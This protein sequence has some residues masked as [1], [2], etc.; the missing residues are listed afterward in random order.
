[1]VAAQIRMF[2]YRTK[3]S[4]LQET[5]YLDRLIRNEVSPSAPYTHKT[6]YVIGKLFRLDRPDERRK[7]RVPSEYQPRLVIYV[8]W[9]PK[10][11]AWEKN[12]GKASMR[13]YRAIRSSTNAQGIG[14][15]VFSSISG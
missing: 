3:L 4:L 14:I 11:R 8:L 2:P 7:N 13:I 5:G 1:M 9:H 6:W 10:F 12:A 15:P